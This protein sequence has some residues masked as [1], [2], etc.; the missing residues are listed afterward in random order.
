MTNATNPKL[1]KTHTI[2]DRAALPLVALAIPI[3][4]ETYFRML[5][6]SADIIMLS[7]YSQESVAGVGLV[8]QYVFFIQ[9]LFNVICIGTSIVLSQ[10]LGG[11]RMEESEQVAQASGLMMCAIAVFVSIVVVIGAKPL[12]GLYTIDPEVRSFA[13]QYLVIFGGGGSL[14]MA[15]SMLQGTILKS[16]GYTRDAMYISFTANILNVIGNSL[17]LYGFFGLPVLGVVGVALSSTFSQFAACLLLA[18]RIRQH[19]EIRFSFRGWKKVPKAIYQKVLSIGG[20]SAG[21]NMAYNISQIVIMMMISTLGTYAMSAQVYG[22]TIVRMVLATPMSIGNAVQI[23]TGYFVGA[24][25]PEE[26][27]RRLYRY[28]I[29]G[30]LIAVTFVVIINIFKVPIIGIFTKVPEIASL[31]Y[32]LLLVSIYIETGRSLNLITIPALKGAG[33]V[34]FPVLFGML[35]MW[36]ISV[37][38]SYLLGI[39]LGMGLTGIWIAIGTDEMVRGIVM[40]FRWKSKRWMLKAIA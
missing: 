12:L 18:W 28:Q 23:K 36:G 21:E 13:W 9:I 22:L 15:F 34:R 37:P 30:T 27:Y 40:L 2:R 5:V 16:Y 8:T 14:F 33:D 6:S 24:K 4:L 20:P 3:I 31:T 7:S 26:A 39:K 35:F 38:G 17:S 29:I 10:Y 11:K 1:L 19:P 32:S 25:K